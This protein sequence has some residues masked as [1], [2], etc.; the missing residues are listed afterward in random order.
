MNQR[1][2]S[3]AG[4]PAAAKVALPLEENEPAT[5]PPQS[6][7]QDAAIFETEP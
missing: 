6:P 2:I 1:V 7:S 5:Q 3:D 4:S